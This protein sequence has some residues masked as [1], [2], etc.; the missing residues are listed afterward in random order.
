MS[1]RSTSDVD[2]PGAGGRFGRPT[3]AHVAAALPRL[4]VHAHALQPLPEQ[5]SGRTVFLAEDDNGRLRVSVLG[6]YEADAQLLARVW[7]FLAYKDVPPVLRMTRHGQVEHEAA[8][9]RRARDA[10]ARI[11][12]VVAVGRVGAL[13]MLVERVPSGRRFCDLRSGEISDRLLDAMWADL[14]AFHATGIVHG[15]LDGHHVVVDGDSPA[16]VGF[17][18]ASEGHRLYGVPGDVAQLLAATAAAVGDE[19]AIAAARRGADPDALRAALSFLQPR[20][21]SGWTHDAFGDPAALENRLDELRAATARALGVEPPALR[22]LYRVHPRTVLMTIGTLVAVGTLMSQV[23]DPVHF[24]NTVRDADWALVVVAL[25]LALLSDV[26]FGITFLGNVPIRIPVW[27]S[28]ELQISMAFSNLAVPVAA[29]VAIQIR[30]LQKNGL[31]LAS[32]TATGGV[33]SSITEIAVQIALFV[34]ALR[35]SP[36]TIHFGRIDTGEAV[37][38]IL[39]AVFLAGVVTAV[40]V[41]VRRLR[42]IVI[43]PVARAARTVWQAIRSPARLALLIGG[44]VVA[45]LIYAASLLACL[46][47]FGAGLS[48][49]SVLAVNIGISAIASLLPVPGGDIAVSAIGRAGML[50]ALGV[51]HAAAAAAVLT[52]QVVH[53]Y[54]PAIPGWFATKDLLRKGLL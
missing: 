27:P 3:A 10:G 47:A 24:W 49:W 1:E 53:S 45:Q 37:V 12:E 15:K 38:V 5:P 8:L 36:D 32:A 2:A 17:E 43:P 52:H 22:Q 6:R 34:V 18:F 23:G 48:F 42:Q 40:V 50:T 41:R 19:R 33:L 13:A 4:G 31:D 26:V 28:I 51:P 39:V 9:A 46:H 11:G 44:N 54:L 14:G 20:S 29:D 35:L 7:R 30:F 16:I 25:V 21:I